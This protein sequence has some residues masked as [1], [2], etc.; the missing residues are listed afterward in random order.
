MI[1]NANKTL[2]NENSGTLPQLDDG[3]RNWY[4]KMKLLKITK[5]VDNFVAKESTMAIDCFGTFQPMSPA[6]IQMRPEGQRD[7]KWFIIHTNTALP[8]EGDDV[9]KYLGKNYR[10]KDHN[11]A[12]LYGVFQY[13]VVEDYQGSAINES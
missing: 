12:R 10:V 13:N 11:D 5:T 8:L 1:K 4:Q 3:L 2:L 7:W 6:Q 9:F